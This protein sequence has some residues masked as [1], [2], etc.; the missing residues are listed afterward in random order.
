MQTS[1]GPKDPFEAS[2]P[3]LFPQPEAKSIKAG[4]K[5]G[6]DDRIIRAGGAARRSTQHPTSAK[7]APPAPSGATKSFI[8]PARIR[9]RAVCVCARRWGVVLWERR[10]PPRPLRG[11]PSPRGGGYEIARYFNGLV[12]ASRSPPPRGE[13]LGVGGERNFWKERLWR[14]RS[15]SAC[16]A[17]HPVSLR[18]PT[19]PTRG[20]V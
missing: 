2:R 5:C 1:G 11:R 9:V 18:E 4:A 19:L 3:S 15:R 6:S 17:P 10:S 12:H 13:G 8:N 14:P 20:R 7:T 16:A